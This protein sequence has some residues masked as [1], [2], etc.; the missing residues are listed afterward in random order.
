LFVCLLVLFIAAFLQFKKSEDA[1]Y[2][3]EKLNGFELAGKALRIGLVNDRE[4][5]AAMNSALDEIDNGGLHLNQQAR[6]QL[7]ASL[8]RETITLP[9]PA[10]AIPTRTILLKNLFDPAEETEPNWPEDIRVDVTEE[11]SKFG[12]VLH[13]YVEKES[14]VNI[15]PYFFSSRF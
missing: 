7:M 8:S 11:C 12:R 15:F 9:L 10:S 5:G 3:L 13:S 14:K 1:R 2:A 4:A 6:M